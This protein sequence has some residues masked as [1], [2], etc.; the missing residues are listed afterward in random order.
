MSRKKLLLIVG[1]IFAIIV[2]VSFWIYSFFNGSPTAL[3]D[4]FTNFPWNNNT[5]SF[6]GQDFGS[7]DDF[8]MINVRG[9][10]LRQLTFRSVLTYVEVLDIDKRLMRYLEAGT[11]HIYEIN[12]ETGEEIRLSNITIPNA[13]EAIFTQSGSYAIVRAGSSLTSEIVFINLKQTEPKRES[14]PI[15]PNQLLSGPS[16]SFFYSTAGRNGLEVRSRDLNTNID[17]LAFIIPFTSATI[18]IGL[19]NTH[20]PFLYTKPASLLFG[21]AYEVN[22]SNNLVRLPVSGNSLTGIHTGEYIIFNR[23]QGDI[24]RSEIYN[25]SNGNIINSSIIALPEKCGVSRLDTSMIFCGYTISRY[26]YHYPEEWY[27]GVRT[28][29]DSL[30]AINLSTGSAIQ[31]VIP[32]AVTGRTLDI[33][34]VSNGTDGKMVYFLNIADKTL[35]VYE[36]TN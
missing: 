30:W 8:P 11:G 23:L 9:N 22:Q 4:R 35:W 31:L 5:D 3:D 33:Y 36:L 15:T 16:D 14:V 26:D 24:Y 27:K 6:E 29:T 25:R 12:M 18:Q 2:V 1:F 32:Q 7:I 13:Y 17:T 34:N 19:N 20:P 28:F 21:Y 10:S